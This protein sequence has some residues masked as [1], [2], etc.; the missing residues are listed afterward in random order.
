MLKYSLPAGA[1]GYNPDSVKEWKTMKIPFIKMS[2]AGND[3]VIFDARLAPITLTPE[4][5]REIATR[6]NAVTGGC[7]QLIIMEPSTRADVFMRIYNADGTEVD[8]CGNATRCIGWKIIEEKADVRY[9]P[10]I[11][12]NAGILS[13]RANE[14]VSTHFRNQGM[15]LEANLGSPRFKPDEIP[16]GGEFSTTLLKNIAKE[17]GL[18]NVVDAT[19][20]GMGNPHVVFFVSSLPHFSKLTEFG[21]A[22][23]TVPLFAE[24]GVNLSIAQ[25]GERVIFSYVYE[26]GA[27]ITKSCGTAACAT[28]VAAITLKYHKKNT[29]IQIQQLQ[30]QAQDLFVR[31]EAKSNHVFLIGPVKTEFERIV[32][33]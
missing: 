17:I 1:L 26:R 30:Q 3:F 20:V 5:I 23:K 32:D 29:N 4:Q 27:G 13:V 21:E 31:W 6:D 19:C 15:V 33:I 9:E 22:I 10:R 2:G 7:D 11:E 8:A 16:V 24:H 18:A 12:T 14:D 25:L 28:A